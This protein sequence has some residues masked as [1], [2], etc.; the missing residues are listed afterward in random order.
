[1]RRRSREHLGTRRT[2]LEWVG[3]ASDQHPTLQAGE[4][5]I[6]RDITFNR[7][8]DG[9]IVEMREYAVVVTESPTQVPGS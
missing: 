1:M 7:F 9:K 2:R 6:L 5:Q 8:R 4:R 3:T